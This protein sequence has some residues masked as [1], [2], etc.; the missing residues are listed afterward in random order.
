M[1]QPLSELDLHLK[2]KV[3]I[4]ISTYI[5]SVENK[6]PKEFVLR[7]MPSDELMISVY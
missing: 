6:L 4:N 1:S 3:L 7:L 5:L 2:Y